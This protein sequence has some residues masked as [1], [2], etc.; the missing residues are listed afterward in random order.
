M[1]R[2]GFLT[3]WAMTALSTGGCGSNGCGPVVPDPCEQDRL[4]CDDPIDEEFPIRADCGLTDPLEVTLGEGEESFH[5]LGAA[6]DQPTIHYG[7]QGGQHTFLAFRVENPALELYDRLRVTLWVAQGP[8]CAAGEP[9]G[10]VP[11]TCAST[12]GIRQVILGAPPDTLHTADGAVEESGLLVFL[13][14]PDF[15]QR[16]VFAVEVEDPCGRVGS[17]SFTVPE[18]GWTNQQ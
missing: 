12:L 14:Y 15:T 4:G 7:V 5:A 18:D 13:S 10:A 9:Q 11:T 6:G 2:T 17:A 8:D 3:I 1:T 16:T